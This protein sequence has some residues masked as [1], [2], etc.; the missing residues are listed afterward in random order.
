[1][2]TSQKGWATARATKLTRG[3]RVMAWGYIMHTTYYTA[4]R[5]TRTVE[6]YMTEKVTRREKKNSPEILGIL[7]AKMETNNI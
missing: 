4:T 1:M 7:R 5:E 3:D 6:I 2:I